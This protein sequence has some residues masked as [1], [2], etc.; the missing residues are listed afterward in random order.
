MRTH[1]TIA[2][3]TL[4]LARVGW[5]QDCPSALPVAASLGFR[6]YAC[7]GGD[8][9]IAV[10]EGGVLH[11]D[12]TVEPRLRGVEPSGPAAGTLREND[13]LVAIDGALVTTRAGGERLANLSPAR[14]VTLRLR[15]DGV[16]MEVRVRPQAGCHRPGISV[17]AN[18][19]AEQDAQSRV[20]ALLA[21]AER[22][23]EA[24]AP[25]SFGLVL[26]CGDCGWRRRGGGS[27][28]FQSSVLPVVMRVDRDSPASRA[29]LLPG[30]TLVSVAGAS[31][32]GGDRSRAWSAL[33]PGQPVVVSIRRGRAVD[34]RI[35]PDGRPRRF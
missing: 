26:E 27:A 8:C 24:E 1:H 7:Y 30:D 17:A 13:V 3:L 4:V 29:G 5:S 15:R 10:R 19:A 2:A 11:H 20:R 12:F 18:E 9:Q 35:T 25:V 23:S 32:V 14:D 21:R 34:L 16:E 28:Y 22:G 31:F 6:S 33:Q